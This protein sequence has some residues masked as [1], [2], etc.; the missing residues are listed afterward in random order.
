M[1]SRPSIA[2]AQSATRVMLVLAGR[3]PSAIAHQSIE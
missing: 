2:Q 3:E 1:T